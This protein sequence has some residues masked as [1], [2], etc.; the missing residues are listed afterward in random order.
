MKELTVRGPA[1]RLHAQDGN[2]LL[3]VLAIFLCT[4]FIYRDL[5]LPTTLGWGLLL[6]FALLNAALRIR[7]SSIL[8]VGRDELVYLLIACVIVLS[9]LRS[10]S[11]HDEDE[12]LYVIAMGVSALFVFLSDPSLEELKKVCKIFRIV[13]LGIA[14]WILFFKLFPSIYWATVYRFIDPSCQ[15]LAAYYVPRG[16]G[17]P[18]GGS[19]TLGYYIMVVG[20][21]LS[22]IQNYSSDGE[23]LRFTR[24]IWNLLYIIIILVAMVAEGRRGE[25]LSALVAMLYLFL[26]SKNT[27]NFLLKGIVILAVF[28]ILSGTYTYILE[29]VKTIPFFRR[30]VLTI[31]G[32]LSGDDITSGRTQ[33]W[34]LA[35][36]L[37]AS[38]PLFGIGF[39]GFAYHI[40][41]QFRVIHGSDVMDVH[42]CTLQLLCETGI[43][44]TIAILLPMTV[45]FFR[46]HRHSATLKRIEH[47]EPAIRMASLLDKTSIGIQ[48]FFLVLSQMDPAFYKPVFWGFYSLAAIMTISAQKLTSRSVHADSPERAL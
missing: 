43:V 36:S 16:Y 2:G 48:V 18:I 26:F 9:L 11:R 40:P 7:N 23:K 39:G 5:G 32:I 33:L 27:T 30:Y 15:A 24:R 35:I 47:D 17:I 8:V 44:G 19:F 3:V 14:L 46:A 31:E 20:L 34:A 42:N 4:F 10:K 25:L 28:V 38:A 12:V 21:L 22:F 13:S 41:H 29:A 37:F 1:I 45:I 6:A